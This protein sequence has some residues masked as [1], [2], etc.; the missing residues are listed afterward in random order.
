[1]PEGW[2]GQGQRRMG[3]LSFTI[4]FNWVNSTN[5]SHLSEFGLAQRFR[6]RA[7]N[8]GQVN[9][10]VGKFNDGLLSFIVGIINH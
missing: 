9:E 1:M 7:A 10:F 8:L 6:I 5:V 3:H 4:K 2:L